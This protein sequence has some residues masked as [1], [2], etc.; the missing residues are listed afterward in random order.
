[1]F[2]T[3][4]FSVADCY[5][6]YIVWGVKM[7]MNNAFIPETGFI[8]LSAILKVFPVSKTTWWVGVKSGRYPKSYKLGRR[9]TVWRAEDIK[10]LVHSSIEENSKSTG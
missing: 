7:N 10:A 1:M 4:A 2:L 3:Y 6:R 8:R 5:G 9:I